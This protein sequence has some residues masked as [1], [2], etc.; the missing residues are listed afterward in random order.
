MATNPLPRRTYHSLS[1]AGSNVACT[2]CRRIKMK[3]VVTAG[4]SR[5]NRCQRKNFECLFESHRRGRR[6]GSKSVL[7]TPGLHRASKT[8]HRVKA[9]SRVASNEHAT[10]N[11]T[12]SRPQ[13]P[14]VFL[15]HP[16]E[17][18]PKGHG[19][20]CR[21]H[22]VSES[23]RNNHSP[24]S[25]QESGPSLAPAGLLHS[26]AITG[27]FSLRNVFRVPGT[28]AATDKSPASNTIQHINNPSSDPIISGIVDM[29]IARNLFDS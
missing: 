18:L 4:E 1:S 23:S 15:Q 3:C 6:P 25:T 14:E 27:E 22:A 16:E 9:V 21:P 13:H 28:V 29:P 26:E 8:C 20:G 24:Y 7:L 19:N 2:G 17:S 10:E 12:P 5:C 11:N